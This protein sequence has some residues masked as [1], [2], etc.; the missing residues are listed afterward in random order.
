M[1]VQANTQIC[2]SPI[3]DPEAETP[4][5]TSLSAHLIVVKGPLPGTMFRITELAASVGRSV[6]NTFQIIDASVSRRHASF[7]TDAAGCVSLTDEGSANGTFVN[8]RRIPAHRRTRLKDGDRIHLGAAVLLKLVRLDAADER[9]QRELFERAVRD[10]L[11]GLH[12]RSYFFNRI[13]QLA[14]RAAV[15]GF[16]LAVLMLDIDHFKRIND[17]YGHLLG[18]QVLRDVAGV[19]RESTRP[20]DIVAR[21]GGEEFVIAL[22][23]STARLASEIAERIRSNLAG[24]RDIAGDADIRITASL[25]MAYA[26]SGRSPSLFA[27]IRTADQALYQAKLNGR[28]RVVF[29]NAGS[30]QAV[31]TTSSAEISIFGLTT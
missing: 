5:P 2:D 18:D 27:L 4:L 16:L 10:P 28:N 3:A 26:P 7:S 24:R 19:I 15:E 9:L 22:P 21:Y 14:E 20:D 23:V 12:N 17:R 31:T 8:G 1:D 29:G 30:S 25:G 13:G 6:G 11:T